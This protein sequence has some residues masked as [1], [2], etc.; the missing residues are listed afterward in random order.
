M[1]KIVEQY[2]EIGEFLQDGI[3]LEKL[4]GMREKLQEQHF[5]L[6]IVGQFSSGKSS[7]INNLIGRRILPTMLSETTAFT[8]FIYY[9]ETEFAEIVTANKSIK[10]EVEQLMA[11]SQRNLQS[12]TSVSELLKIEPIQNVDIVCINVYLQHELFKTGI[13]LVDTP[14]LNTIISNHENRTIDIIPK[15]HAVLYIMGKALTAADVQLVSMI[16]QLGIDVLFVRTKLDELRKDENDTPKKIMQQDQMLLEDAIGRKATYFGVTNEVDLLVFPHWKELMDDFIQFLQVQFVHNIDEKKSKSVTRQLTLVKDD[17]LRNLNERKL[18]LEVSK[19]VTDQDIHQKI[20]NLQGEIE[21]VHERIQKQEQ[22][23][24][25]LFEATKKSIVSKYEMQFKQTVLDFTQALRTYNTVEELQHAADLQAEQQ[26]QNLT[27]EIKDFTNDKL[28]AF[29]KQSAAE[30]NEAL[31]DKIGQFSL[32]N[33][34]NI[35]LQVDV[36]SVDD[37]FTQGEMIREKIEGSSAYD[38]RIQE[39]AAQRQ[40]MEQQAVSISAQMQSANE[41]MQQLGGYEAK[42]IQKQDTSSQETLSAFGNIVDIAMIFIPG[43]AFSTGAAKVAGVIKNVADGT[44]YVNQAAKIASGVEKAGKVLAKTD[45]IKDATKLLETAQNSQRGEGKES[46]FNILNLLSLEYWFGQVGKAIDGPPQIV[47]DEQHRE[48]YLHEKSK[49]EA[50]VEH[51]RQLELSR[52]QQLSLL[53]TREEKLREEKRLQEKY[54]QQL[55]QEMFELEQKR[56]Q[57]LKEQQVVSYRQQ[58]IQQFELQL[59]KLL[60]SYR[61]NMQEYLARFI[62]YLPTVISLKLQQQLHLQKQQLEELTALRQQNKE[63]QVEYEQQLFKYLHLL[64]S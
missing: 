63:V 54:E 59:K 8:T 56:T 21:Y 26:I 34:P 35:Q 12:P 47:E 23:F 13:V 1:Q 57:Q 4:S 22:N 24:H 15:A 20:A 29:L 5:Y 64:N 30:T 52:M 2:I 50:K 51:A 49:I 38:E 3:A 28:N 55:K 39:I 48:A 42:Y 46:K 6:P 61:E 36:P 9:G 41:E 27:L 40:K 18:Q 62:A 10:F 53:E 33:V 60:A 25:S 45:K 19:S 16:D 11:L 14:G 58:L 17:F 43:K 44:K 32:S 31:Q 7:L 37:I